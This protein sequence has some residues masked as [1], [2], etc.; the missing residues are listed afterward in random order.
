MAA[1]PTGSRLVRARRSDPAQSPKFKYL[2]SLVFAQDVG[3]PGGGTPRGPR[4]STSRPLH[5]VAGVQVIFHGRFWVITEDGVRIRDAGAPADLAGAVRINY[6]KVTEHS[7]IGERSTALSRVVPDRRS[8]RVGAAL[9]GSAELRQIPFLI[10]VGGSSGGS[11]ATQ[12]GSSNG[13][14]EV[15]SGSVRCLC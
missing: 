1:T 15:R 6:S 13:S 9:S 14:R 3:H 11:M 5:L 10:G 8:R 7:A 2:L 4:P 12:P